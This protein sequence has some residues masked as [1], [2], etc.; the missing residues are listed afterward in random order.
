M[1]KERN[2]FF[3]DEVDLTAELKKKIEDIST[4]KPVEIND[5][6]KGKRAVKNALNN[7]LTQPFELRESKIDGSLW[8]KLKPVSEQKLLIGQSLKKHIFKQLLTAKPYE[9]FTF[10]I[11]PVRVPYA[12]VQISAIAK[13]LGLKIRTRFSQKSEKFLVKISNGK[14][15]AHAVLQELNKGQ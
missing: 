14:N 5:Y 13:D 9:F 8:V 1:Q 15:N 7:I 2:P 11:D 12:R 6:S 4:G 3:N 10:Q